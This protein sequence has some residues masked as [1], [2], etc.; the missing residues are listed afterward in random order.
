MGLAEIIEAFTGTEFQD[1]RDAAAEHG[2]SIQQLI[3]DA[4]MDRVAA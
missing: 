1:I 2:V 3:H 4:V